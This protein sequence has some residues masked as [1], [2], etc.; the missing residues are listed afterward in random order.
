[1]SVRPAFCTH[2]PISHV[3]SGYTPLHIP[4]T[5]NNILLV[6]EIGGDLNGPSGSWMNNLLARA[7]I[8]RT[9]T[10]TVSCVGCTPPDN[11]WPTDRKWK[12]T[13]RSDAYSAVA[14]CREH[15]LL[16]A[17]AEAAPDKIITLG[18][19]AL[20]AL[21]PARPLWC[22]GAAP[23]PSVATCPVPASS[24]PSTPNNL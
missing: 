13:P 18:D 17:V 2:C 14:Y 7:G 11:L 21:T 3:T 1:M 9:E 12:A 24:P 16:P 4:K 19:A 6:S 22:G 10:A 23:S 8:K 5:P 20:E 15:H